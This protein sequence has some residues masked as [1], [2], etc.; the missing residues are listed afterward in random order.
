MSYNET[1]NVT[2]IME[3]YDSLM[4]QITNLM[5]DSE[6]FDLPGFLDSTAWDQAFE[7]I[8]GFYANNMDWIQ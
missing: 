4:V 1:V 6:D 2:K 8:M 5:T 3:R 7:T